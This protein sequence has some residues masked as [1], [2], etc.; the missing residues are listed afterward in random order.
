M[1]SLEDKLFSSEEWV[2]IQR[3]FND[4]EANV[5]NPF[6]EGDVYSADEIYSWIQ[7]LDDDEW[8]DYKYYDE[9]PFG[10][11]SRYRDK[12]LCNLFSI[13]VSDDGLGRGGIVVFEK[14]CEDE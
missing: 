6:Y 5:Q 3:G 10:K 14:Q 12:K 13:Y 8:M 11:I 1:V 9:K 2:C 4:F 7:E